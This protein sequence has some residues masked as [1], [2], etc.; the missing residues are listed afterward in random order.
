MTP[1]SSEEQQLRT[2]QSMAS[3]TVSDSTTSLAQSHLTAR[4]ES[5]HSS[6]WESIAASPLSSRVDFALPGVASRVS[7]KSDFQPLNETLLSVESLECLKE[8]DVRSEVSPAP[9]IVTRPIRQKI[10]LRDSSDDYYV[11]R[12][13]RLVKKEDKKSLVRTIKESDDSSAAVLS[14]FKSPE[15]YRSFK[16]R[17]REEPEESGAA[18]KSAQ[19]PNGEVKASQV[20][21]EKAKQ[22]HELALRNRGKISHYL[23]GRAS[24]VAGIPSGFR[25]QLHARTDTDLQSQTIKEEEVVEEKVNLAGI[26]NTELHAGGKLRRRLS[27]PR[28][29]T[30]DVPTG[31]DS[32]RR[33]SMLQIPGGLPQRRASL[34]SPP[35]PA[36]ST[37]DLSSGSP[38]LER[39]TSSRESVTTDRQNSS[40]GHADLARHDS[41]HQPRKGVLYKLSSRTS[42]ASGANPGV[43]VKTNSYP[44]AK[45]DAGLENSDEVLV[46]SPY[47]PPKSHSNGTFL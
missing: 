14:V 37:S 7:L 16:S 13:I 47:V 38:V 4:S 29:D 8:Q 18:G 26:D 22:M 43:F 27:L 3:R 45:P 5:V 15:A 12:R 1:S 23:A 32:H 11:K 2:S 39:K 42:S 6:R 41:L 44:E 30:L 34:M 24:Q 25:A 17:Y 28:G 36:A 46:E 33:A 20:R 40:S 9:A 19:D 35:P 10:S 31:G 21:I